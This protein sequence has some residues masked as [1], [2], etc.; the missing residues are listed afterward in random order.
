MAAPWAGAFP[1][2]SAGHLSRAPPQ[3]FPLGTS[4]RMGSSCSLPRRCLSGEGLSPEPPP[5]LLHPSL[6]FL[7]SSSHPSRSCCQRPAPHAASGQPTPQAPGSS[8][9]HR[10]SGLP[11]E[12]SGLAA[13]TVPPPIPHKFLEPCSGRGGGH[14][15]LNLSRKRWVWLGRQQPREAW[16]LWA[17]RF[18]VSGCQ[19]LL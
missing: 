1:A 7:W 15:T 6:S 4:P 10:S 14:R 17:R 5:P 9:A 11:L 16:G 12:A 2:A 8:T 13:G 19:T 18:W 3:A